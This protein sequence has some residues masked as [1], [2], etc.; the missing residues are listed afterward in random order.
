M[1]NRWWL[2][3]CGTQLIA[4]AACNAS[5]PVWLRLVAG[6]LLL[7]GTLLML[8]V[9]TSVASVVGNGGLEAVVVAALIGVNACS[10]LLTYRVRRWM[11]HRNK[12]L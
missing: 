11:I 1:S 5:N 6:A 4:F 10:W 12:E 9:S 7:P 8:L 2:L 3:F